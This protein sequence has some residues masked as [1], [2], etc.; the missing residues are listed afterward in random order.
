MATAGAEGNILGEYVTLV[1][2]FAVR[3]LPLDMVEDV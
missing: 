2:T 3:I 1:A